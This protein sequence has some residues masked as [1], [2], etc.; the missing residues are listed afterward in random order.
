MSKQNNSKTLGHNVLALH[1]QHPICARDFFCKWQ[2]DEIWNNTLHVHVCAIEAANPARV[3]SDTNDDLR[4]IGADATR[5]HQ[6]TTRDAFIQASLLFH[7]ETASGD[8][9]CHISHNATA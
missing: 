2:G 5:Q 9:P 4:Q 7:T 3:V 6:G 1:P 8:V